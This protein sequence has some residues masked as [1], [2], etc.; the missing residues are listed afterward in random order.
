[1]VDIGENHTN[2]PVSLRKLAKRQE[3][4]LKYMEQIIPL[5]KASGLVRSARGAKGGYFLAKHPKEISLL[6]VLQAL[7]GPLV[8]VECLEDKNHCRRARECATY[9]IWQDIQQAIQ[10]VLQKTTLEDIIIS[11]QKK[12]KNGRPVP[13][14][15]ALA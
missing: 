2:G 13:C 6:E 3:I 15:E 1:M 7:E 9:D 12:Q 5:L 4:S 10:K 14:P 8:L 11:R